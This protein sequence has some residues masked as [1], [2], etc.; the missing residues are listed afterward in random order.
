MAG[1]WNRTDAL[2]LREIVERINF[3]GCGT[4]AHWECVLELLERAENHDAKGSFYRFFNEKD[5]ADPRDPWIEFGA[6]CL[7][8]WD[9]IDHGT[10]IGW[11][12]L[13]DDGKLLLRFLREFS[14]DDQVEHTATDGKWPLWAVEFGWTSEAKPG[15]AFAEWEAKQSALN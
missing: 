4:N 8:S 2:K 9:L 13:T 15:D 5:R 1:K 10:G 11:A 14:T 3:C 7:D 12:W 6:K